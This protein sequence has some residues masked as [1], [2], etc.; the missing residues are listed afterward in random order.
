MAEEPGAREPRIRRALPVT[1][2]GPGQDAAPPRAGGEEPREEEEEEEDEGPQDTATAVTVTA[3]GT[4]PVPG[5]TLHPEGDPEECGDPGAVSP[6]DGTAEQEEPEAEPGPPPGPPPAGPPEEEGGGSCSSSDDD[7][8]GLRR[9]QSHEPRPGGPCPPPAP[10]RGTPDTSA[11]DTSTGDGLSVS[12]CLLGVLALVAVGLLIVTGGIYDAADGP[13]QSVV[14]RDTVPGQQEQPLP[15]DNNDSQQEPPVMEPGDPRGLQP[16]SQLLDRLARENQEI[17]LMQAELQ[18]HKEELQA[19]L[20]QSRGEAAVA[21][22]QRQSLAAE[23]A[24]LHAALEREAAALSEAR[25]EL[26]RLRGPGAP[27]SPGMAAQEEPPGAPGRGD[28]ARWH[29]RVAAVRRELVGALERAR[30]AGGLG[31]LV[32]E[33]SAL[34]QRLGRELEAAEPFPGPLRKEKKRHKERE[35]GKAPGHGKDP[36]GHKPGKPWGKSPRGSH[37][38]PPLGRYRAPQGCSGV[39]ECAR[40][41]GL[42]VLGAALEPVQKEPFLRLLEEF[43]GGLGWGGHF[44]GVAARLDGAF[45]PDGV[46]AHDRL[47]FV[48]FVDDVEEALEELERRERRHGHEADGFEEF[49]LRHY[50]G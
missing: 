40:K 19:L 7:T 3:T 12:K 29:G 49:V 32:A 42:E 9:R 17:R 43:M 28:G 2:L 26:Q 33:L 31:G 11:G 18:A 13:V 50:R 22:A 36:R 25:A 27:G 34:E 4:A 21:G 23:N 5:Q 15:G 46:F 41:E 38:L 20:R 24:R 14:S 10:H 48:D 47:R 45:G 44:G 6:P 39:T 1:T 35:A 8:E 16:L 30:G 37:E